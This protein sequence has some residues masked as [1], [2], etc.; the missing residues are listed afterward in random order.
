MPYYVKVTKK[1]REAILPAYLVVRRTFDGNFL[2]YQS[3]LERVEGNTLRE[4]CDNVGGALLTPLEAKG[5]IAG[6]ICKPCY[7]P[8][9][10]GGDDNENDTSS[11][12]AGMMGGSGYIPGT[13]ND[14]TPDVGDKDS[15]A[16]NEGSETGSEGS[17]T[18]ENGEQKAE[19]NGEQEA[20]GDNA[21]SVPSDSI[22]GQD[23]SQPPAESSSEAATPTENTN[24]N[25][26]QKKESEVTD[27]P[28]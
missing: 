9:A 2:I 7:T 28:E 3:A 8:K 1:V 13:G 14:N 11:S 15:E 6:T 12:N 26:N 22:A 5:E 27:E 20:G 24:K 10:Y 17:E 23:C 19:E 16:G 21:A 25:N 4:R 18:E